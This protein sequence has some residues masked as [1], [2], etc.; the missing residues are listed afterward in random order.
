MSAIGGDTKEDKDQIKTTIEE[1]FWRG[2][3]CKIKNSSNKVVK[4]VSKIQQLFLH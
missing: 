4:L 3:S 2:H 1:S